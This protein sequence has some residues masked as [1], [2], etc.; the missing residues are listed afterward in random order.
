MHTVIKLKLGTH[1]RLLKLN[2]STNFGA[3]LMEIYRVII[4]YLHKTKLLFCH[5]YRVNPAS[6]NELKLG[7][8]H[9]RSAFL[10]FEM[11]RYDTKPNV[12][13]NKVI[14]FCKQKIY[15]CTFHACQVNHLKVVN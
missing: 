13:Q 3:N 8:Y 4:N 11:K 15:Y 10:L 1:K 2:R 12:C 7:M 6:R 5:A 9:H 14:D